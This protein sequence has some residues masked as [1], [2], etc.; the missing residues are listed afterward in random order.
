MDDLRL[1][2]VN[3]LN[4]MRF[5]KTDDVPMIAVREKKVILST[6]TVAG[7]PFIVSHD[8][9]T[10]LERVGISVLGP[11]IPEYE[12]SI[13]A[14]DSV[15]FRLLMNKTVGSVEHLQRVRTL[16]W[17]QDNPFQIGSRGECNDPDQYFLFADA[18]HI[19]EAEYWFDAV[20]PGIHVPHWATTITPTVTDR[21]FIE[22]TFPDRP[23]ELLFVGS[24]NLEQLQE[25]LMKLNA[26]PSH[27]LDLAKGTLDLIRSGDTRS[28]TGIGMAVDDSLSLGIHASDRK[29][30]REILR[31]VDTFV[32]MENRVNLFRALN[33][34]DI[35]VVSSQF[36]AVSSLVGPKA[37][38]MVAHGASRQSDPFFL[39]L[40]AMCHA[41]LTINNLP[42]YRNGVTERFFNAQIR[43]SAV[44]SE[45]NSYLENNFTDDK[46]VFLYDP[47]NLTDIKERV[48]HI[49]NDRD[50]LKEVA[51]NGFDKTYSQH[52]IDNRL[53]LILS[54]H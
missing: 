45:K 14:Q 12:R 31:L 6:D 9:R 27:L 24:V 16:S 54:P 41:K 15:R 42:N 1:R 38:Q 29:V 46:D 10:G 5:S 51:L 22:K 34:M 4:F 8:F 36:G 7:F 33:G 2:K 43:G 11:T 30:F 26:L 37:K 20:N 18:D 23:I 49:L 53:D 28:V 35:T 52:L 39:G 21:E 3:V 32:R 13:E 19:S 25:H 48:R 47:Y 50:K 44:L 17:M 40:Y